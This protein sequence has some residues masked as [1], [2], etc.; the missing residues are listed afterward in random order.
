M[1]NPALR[2]LLHRLMERVLQPRKKSCETIAEFSNKG[3]NQ[4]RQIVIGSIDAERREG[5]RLY[6]LLRWL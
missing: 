3:Q 5:F 2:I 6:Y 1:I 4:T